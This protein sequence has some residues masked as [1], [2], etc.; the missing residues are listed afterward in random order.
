[1]ENP[2]EVHLPAAK[3]VLRYLKGTIGLEFSI[4]NEEMMILLHTLTVVRLEIWMRERILQAMC[5]Y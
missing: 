4:G 3:R 5:S 2:T 1:M